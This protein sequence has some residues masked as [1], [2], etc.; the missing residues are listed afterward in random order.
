MQ[1]D[2]CQKS[3]SQNSDILK[4]KQI[5]NGGREKPFTCDLCQKMYYDQ[6]ELNIT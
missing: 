1:C 2:I 4:H 6:R 3:F 5:H